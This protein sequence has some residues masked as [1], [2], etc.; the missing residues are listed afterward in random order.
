MATSV[1]V[2]DPAKAK[3]YFEAKMAFTTGPVELERMIKAQEAIVID[4]RAEEDY[5]EGHIP[6][7][8]NLP[9][10]KWD[11]ASALR[12]DKVNVLYCYSQTCHLAASAA[13][14]FS[15]KGYPV[16]E[17]EGGIATWKEKEFDIEK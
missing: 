9:K 11:T 15:G 12:K 2:T 7:A 6:S 8:T 14:E 13:L 5:A 16:M 1:K 3:A 10:T 17:L 4:V